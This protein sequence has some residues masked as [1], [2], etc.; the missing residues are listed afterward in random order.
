MRPATVI[1]L[2]VGALFAAAS[3][4]LGLSASSHAQP[5]KT[6]A[7]PILLELFTSQGCSSCPPADELLNAWRDKPGVI[8]LSFSVDY[9]NYL[10]WHDTLSSPE[11]SERQRDYALARGDGRVYTPQMVVDGI[12][13]VNGANEAAIEMAMRNAERRLKNVKVPIS[14]QAEGNSLVVDIGAAPELRHARGDGVARG[15]EGQGDRR[16]FPRRESRQGNHLLPPGARAHAIGMWK[17][18]QMTLRLPLNEL[19]TIGG[20]CLVAMLQVEGSGPIL[21]AAAY[22]RE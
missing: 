12:T 9:W 1:A 5:P 7:T 14:M 10:G 20:D 3:G 4:L 11:N 21:G 17:G 6:P 19:Q 8:T 18:E 13:H 2:G 22:E 16:H 15:G